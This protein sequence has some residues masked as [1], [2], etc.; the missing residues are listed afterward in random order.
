MSDRKEMV[1]V[2]AG[3]NGSGK[4]TVTAMINKVGEY[5]NADEIART[6]GCDN[7]TAA[8]T[9][10]KMRNDC[11]DNKKDFTFE[12]VLSTPRNIELLKRAKENGYFIK[13]VFVLTA[14]PQ[15][16]VNRVSQRVANGGH[17]VPVEKI[18]SC[19]KR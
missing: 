7:L 1:L 14:S 5:I 2:F 15:I 13:S 10:E 4:S 19:T 9:A 18:V 16:N 8:Q 12:T 11:I 17:D 3:P 6:T